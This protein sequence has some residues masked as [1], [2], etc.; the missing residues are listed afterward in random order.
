MYEPSLMVDKID[1]KGPKSFEWVLTLA[2]LC[3][4]YTEQRVP[5]FFFLISGTE[6]KCSD[7]LWEVRL[8]FSSLHIE[9]RTAITHILR[10]DKT[11]AAIRTC[12]VRQ[13]SKEKEG[14]KKKSSFI[15]L[16]L[17]IIK[18]KKAYLFHADQK[19][20]GNWLVQLVHKLYIPLHSL[21]FPVMNLS[22]DLL[23]LL[24]SK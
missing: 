7:S 2:S 17:E 6:W 15:P 18:K 12:A 11:C 14:K 24:P 19:V 23:L 5:A 21:H 9:R 13:S 8:A 10:D 3:T 22:Q 20:W 16:S 4:A 1:R